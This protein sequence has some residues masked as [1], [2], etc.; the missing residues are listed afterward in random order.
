MD[1]VLPG[2]IAF[3]LFFAN[4]LNDLLLHK[5]WLAFLF[6]AGAILLAA[7]SVAGCVKGTP[8]ISAPFGRILFGIMGFASLVMMLHSLFF[9]IPVSASYRKPGMKRPA[10]SG[11]VYG[12]CRHPGVLFFILLMFC[13]SFCF[14]L[15]LYCSVVWSGLNVLLALFED[16]IV[17]PKLLEGYGNYKETTPFLIP[18][19]T[20][21]GA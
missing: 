15:P 16:L 19:V 1:L 10:A 4:D 18:R 17:F 21:R 11:G 5:K 3:V 6:P 9:A 12:L 8:Y 7:S 2:V 20:R 14:G 13:L